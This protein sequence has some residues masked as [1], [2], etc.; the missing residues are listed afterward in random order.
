[1]VVKLLQPEKA[2]RNISDCGV[3]ERLE[4][5][6]NGMLFNCELF[7]NT[8]SNDLVLYDVTLLNKPLGIVVIFVLANV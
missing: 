1:M 8:C 2:L 3:P 5:K 6:S 7:A 4:N